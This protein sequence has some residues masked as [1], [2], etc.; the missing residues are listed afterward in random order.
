MEQE[1]LE[2]SCFG[3]TLLADERHDFLLAVGLQ[4]NLTQEESGWRFGGTRG[5]RVASVLNYLTLVVERSDFR[6]PTGPSQ[7]LFAGKSGGGEEG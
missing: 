7:R 4:R 3:P 6:L 2:G 5:R 1:T